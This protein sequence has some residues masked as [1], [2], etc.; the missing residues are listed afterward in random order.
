MFY[1]IAVIK[2]FL[3]SLFLTLNATILEPVFD[4]ETMVNNLESSGFSVGISAPDIHSTTC[5]NLNNSKNSIMR[6]FKP[7]KHLLNIIN[8]RLR[9]K[10][11]SPKYQNK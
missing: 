8:F 10:I 2:L 3:S 4:V 5:A 7:F 6:D 11:K 1:L 9:E